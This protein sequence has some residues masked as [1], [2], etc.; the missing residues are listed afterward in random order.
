[1]YHLANISRDICDERFPT[2][3]AAKVYTGSGKGRVVAPGVT[4]HQG[5]AGTVYIGK[6]D[7]L[8]AWGAR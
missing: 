8:R 3:Q 1:M 7:A 4:E 5:Y 6:L 2:K